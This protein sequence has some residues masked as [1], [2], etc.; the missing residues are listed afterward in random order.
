[1]KDKIAV[2]KEYLPSQL[3][4]LKPI[5]SILSKGVHQ[6]SEKECLLY[7]R[8]IKRAI[9]LI[10]EQKIEMDSKRQSDKM[11]KKDIEYIRLLVGQK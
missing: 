11:V 10:L 9:V 7:F 3:V 6:L 8:P 5:Y 1:M 2:L 4:D